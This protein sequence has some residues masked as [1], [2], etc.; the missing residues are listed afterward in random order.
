MK[1]YTFSK[2]II[3]KADFG[4]DDTLEGQFYNRQLN[5]I[6]EKISDFKSRLTSNS[7][8][9]VLPR[10]A[11]EIRRSILLLPPI[12]KIKKMSMYELKNLD[13]QV[14]SIEESMRRY[15][16]KRLKEITGD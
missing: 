11:G 6:V 10:Q 4:H 9:D 12:D 14:D 8:M 5:K 15:S 3:K 16:A 13:K 2:K 1:W 7:V